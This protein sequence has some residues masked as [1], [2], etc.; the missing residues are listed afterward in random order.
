DPAQGAA[1]SLVGQMRLLIPLAGLVDVTEELERL[2]KQL[3]KERQGL[4]STENKL[5]NERFVA[6]APEAVVAKERERLTQHQHAVDEL[7]TQIEKLQ[8]LA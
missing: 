6:N 3:D 8:S 5:A 4:A 2:A 1:V 7:T